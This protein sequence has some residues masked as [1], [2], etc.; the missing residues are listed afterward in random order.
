MARGLYVVDQLP[1]IDTVS[2]AAFNTF[3]SFADIYG[4]PQ[5]IIPKSRQDVGLTLELFAHGEFSL[6]TSATASVGFYF[7][8]AASTA[9]TTLVAPTSILGQTQLL[10]P[11]AATETSAPWMA[12]WWGVLTAVGAGASGGSWKGRGYALLGATATPF[13]TATPW[14]IPTTQALTTVTCDVTADR[15]V[16]VGWQ[17]GT[18]SA[19]NTVKVDGFFAKVCS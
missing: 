7:N 11:G 8:G 3:T 12:Y 2:R 18:S 15:A 1:P 4:A 9:P 10:T 14:L 17:W 5:K 6:V 19:S 13:L 16:G